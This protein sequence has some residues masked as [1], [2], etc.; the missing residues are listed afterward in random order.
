M[1]KVLI[2]ILLALI[3]ISGTAQQKAQKPKVMVVPE[4]A[5]C[6]NSGMYKYGL[7]NT[8]IVDYDAAMRNDNVLDVI[9]TFENLMANYGFQLTNLKQTLDELK[10]ES[11]LD[12]VLSAKDDGVV[13]EED[14]DKLSRVAGADILVKISPK[15]SDYGPD[16]RLELRVSSIDCAS[17]K[18]LMSFGPV[19]KTSAGSVSMMLKAAVTDNIQTFVLGLTKY[20]EDMAAKGREGSIII[21]I[22]DT[23]PLNLESTVKYEGEEGELA[24]L[25]ELWVSENTVNGAYTGHKTSRVAMKF[26][27]VRIPLFGRAAFGR[28][29]ALSM[30]GF[31]KTGLVQLLA[32][33]GISV[34]T[35]AVGIGKVYLTLGGM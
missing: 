13:I 6:I 1:R 25:I 11:A 28:T 12:H 5:F 9:N 8:K 34:S 20:Y 22:A 33:Y 23:C 18:A 17:K 29:K 27:Q 30:E 3:S 24:D 26:D 7:N 31:V 35:H 2:F 32:N 10:E 19:T 16:R 14:L 15:I 21:K 4:D